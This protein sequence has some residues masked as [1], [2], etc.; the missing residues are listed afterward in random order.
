MRFRQGV[1]ASLFLV[2]A[3]VASAQT[4]DEEAIKALIEEVQVCYNDGDPARLMA[5]WA[6]DGV[7]MP[8]GVPALSGMAAIMASEERGMAENSY[9]LVIAIEEVVVLGDWAFARGTYTNTL[10]ATAGGEPFPQDGKWMFIPQRQGDGSWKI[11]RSI[12][13]HNPRTH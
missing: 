6:D 3:T 5:L 8:P 4:S 9:E 1:T 13:N 10:I 12:W 2:V 11:A 7:S